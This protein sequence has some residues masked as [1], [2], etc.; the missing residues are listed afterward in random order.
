MA[1]YQNPIFESSSL[2]GIYSESLLQ[3]AFYFRRED[4]TRPCARYEVFS[5]IYTFVRPRIFY[6]GLCRHCFVILFLM[7]F[8]RSYL[9]VR[10]HFVQLK[11][12]IM[13]LCLFFI[14]EQCMK[15]RNSE[16]IGEIRWKIICSF[17]NIST[18]KVETLMQYREQVNRIASF[19]FTTIC[20]KEYAGSF[21]N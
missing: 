12:I 16:I 20:F 1:P 14:E 5:S 11:E 2:V 7:E 10:F 18:R 15:I 4:E 19:I 3:I 9:N 21:I 8:Q 17:F 13:N 6:S